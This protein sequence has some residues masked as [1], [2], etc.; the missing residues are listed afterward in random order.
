M[1][2]MVRIVQAQY[3]AMHCNP[4]LYIVFLF[5]ITY[6]G[7]HG[8]GGSALNLQVQIRNQQ[9]HQLKVVHIDT[10]S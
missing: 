10:S 3:S 4:G 8:I 1:I 7:H 2:V 9:L 5:Y 6:N